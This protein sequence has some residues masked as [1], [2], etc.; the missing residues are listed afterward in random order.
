MLACYRVFSGSLDQG[1]FIEKAHKSHDGHHEIRHMIYEVDFSGRN[2]A[3]LLN[4]A[5]DT[6]CYPDP[7]DPSLSS[8]S[9]RFCQCAGIDLH[10]HW[11]RLSLEKLKNEKGITLVDSKPRMVTTVGDVRYQE[12]LDSFFK[13]T[14]P[15]EVVCPL[16]AEK[17]RFDPET[18]A[19]HG[20]EYSPPEYDSI[21][22]AKSSW[23]YFIA[24]KYDHPAPDELLLPELVA[25]DVIKTYKQFEPQTFFG[26]KD[27]ERFPGG[28]A[29]DSRGN[30]SCVNWLI[31]GLKRNYGL[32]L[33]SADKQPQ[34]AVVVKLAGYH[35]YLLTTLEH[36]DGFNFETLSDQE[37]L[38]YFRD[39][40][41]EH[42]EHIDSREFERNTLPILGKILPVMDEKYKLIVDCIEMICGMGHAIIEALK[43]NNIDHESIKERMIEFQ[44]LY[45]EM[46]LIQKQFEFYKTVEKIAQKNIDGVNER[47]WARYYTPAKVNEIPYLPAAHF[48]ED[49]LIE[50]FKEWF[51]KFNLEEKEKAISRLKVSGRKLFTAKLKVG[52]QSVLE[53]MLLTISGKL[54][55]LKHSPGNE[56]LKDEYQ[57]WFAITNEILVM[58]GL[59]KPT[60]NES[61]IHRLEPLDL[62]ADL[63]FLRPGQKTGR[64]LHRDKSADGTRSKRGRKCREAF[65]SLEKCGR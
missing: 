5:Q 41:Q 7:S 51:V 28:L 25:N 8:A 6:G 12:R 39:S 42:I 55:D 21:K 61:D 54:I 23:R 50:Y 48:D 43:N 16:F 59:H 29:C 64:R 33:L 19:T 46:V 20:W 18:L 38:S 40:W 49:K 32:S 37:L 2:V 22:E 31:A 34:E 44:S 65:I 53:H 30:G 27:H 52:M 3:V 10:S 57:R 15:G 9:I 36:K 1:I 58:I 24:K 35:D 14:S 11:G 13:E 17:D 60:P 4:F 62:A 56:S 47:R 63:T 26:F 45:R